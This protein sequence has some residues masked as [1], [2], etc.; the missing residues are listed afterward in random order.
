[1]STVN[2][3]LLAAETGCRFVLAASLTE[4]M[5]TV[6]EVRVGSPYAAAK[7]ASGIYAKMF[8][9]LYDVPV[10]LLRPFMTYG[11]GQNESKVIPHV[12]LS[13]L[14]GDAPKLSSGQQQVDWIYVDD[15]VDGFV[16]AACLPHAES[17]IIDL[18]SGTLASVRDI[19]EQLVRLTGAS[20]E[21]LFDAL[22]DRIHEPARVA[23]L[24]DARTILNWQ[25]RIALSEGL[26][27]TV[28]Y[29]RNKLQSVL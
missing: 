21:P 7:W 15:V 29:Y 8:R 4:P 28:E 22:P 23:N 14:R 12:I 16:A 26:A 5:P 13:L 9:D 27:R 24:A 19:V 3:L 20:V 6:A 2:V 18:G 25:P 10:V 11:P 1:V 17:R